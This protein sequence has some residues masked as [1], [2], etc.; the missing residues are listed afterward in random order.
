MVTFRVS[1]PRRREAMGR[2]FM[3]MPENKKN[4]EV[5]AFFA[6]VGIVVG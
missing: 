5:H 3:N 4:K 6:V 2:D 1:D